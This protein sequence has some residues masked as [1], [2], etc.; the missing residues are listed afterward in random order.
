[1]ITSA[2]TAQTAADWWAQRRWPYNRALAIAGIAAFLCYA[3]AFEARCTNVP[4]AEIT[5]F[6]TAFQGVGY[7]VAMAIANVC[8]NLGRWSEAILR[9][10]DPDRYRHRTYRLGLW[11][12][13]ALPFLG[14]LITLWR[15]CVPFG[16]T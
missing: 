12:S 10:R 4:E 8:F 16:A 1:M 11:F 3:A 13:V 7:L 15:G 14:L 2:P 9:P 6:T 5:L